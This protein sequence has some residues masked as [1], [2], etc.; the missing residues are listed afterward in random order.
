MKLCGSKVCV[1]QVL[2]AYFKYRCAGIQK[3]QQMKAYVV[4]WYFWKRLFWREREKNALHRMNASILFNKF[5]IFFDIISS[6]TQTHIVIR[7]IGDA[8]LHVQIFYEIIQNAASLQKSLL[9][10]TYWSDTF[11]LSL[12]KIVVFWMALSNVSP[13]QNS[14]V[15]LC[16]SICGLLEIRKCVKKICVHFEWIATFVAC[17]Q[18]D[19]RTLVTIQQ[20]YI[21]FVCELFI[22]FFVSAARKWRFTF[23]LAKI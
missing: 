10:F 19:D 20:E 16:V 2:V 4:T 5:S 21:S 13:N 7:T 12:S 15:F 23:L 9:L 18:D 17:K 3:K 8:P 6:H 22:C 1:F 11:F 14:F